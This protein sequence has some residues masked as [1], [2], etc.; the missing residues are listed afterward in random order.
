[1][2]TRR[3]CQR[4]V[5]F[6]VVCLLWLQASLA[7]STSAVLAQGF[8]AEQAAA[9]MSVADDLDV[10]LVASEP[11][12]RQ[13]VAL[14]FD[15][16]GR[17]WVIQYLQY[18]NPEGLQRVQVDR[19]SRTQYDR[20]P[21]PPPR[22]PRGAD[23]ISILSDSDADG[24][25]DVAHD[26]VNG[27]NLTTGLAFGD[28]GVYVLN[29]PYL[30]F[31]SDRDQNDQPDADPEVLLSG[32]GMED[33]H[34]VANSLTWGPDGWLY[35]CQGSTVTSVIR[36]QRF[37][38][39]VWRYHPGSREF[40]LFC[41]GGGNSWGLDF[42][43]VGRLFY[44][45][46]YGGFTLVHGVQGASYVK[47]FG[48]HGAL[49]N[50]FAYGYFEHAPHT[51]F[52]GGHVTVGG[53]VYQANALPER[54]RG[55]YVA[56]DLLGHSVQWHQVQPM[57]STVRTE[58]GG[59]LLQANDTWFATSDV[60]TGPDGALYVADWHDARMAH[61]DPDA[62]WDRRN[63]RIYRIG[64]RESDSSA[65]ANGAAFTAYPDATVPQLVAALR[66]PNQW[67]VRQARQELAWRRRSAGVAGAEPRPA[68]SSTPGDDVVATL[69]QQAVG[70]ESVDEALQALWTV[71]SMGQFKESLALPLL[72]SPH[73]AVRSWTVRLLGDGRDISVA[74][75]HR[76]DELAE[77][78]PDVEVRQQLA[79]SARFFPAEHA[80]P[81]INA[82]IN[83][84]IDGEDPFLPL[85]WWWAVEQHSVSGR[86]E[87]LKRFVRPTLWNSRL[88]RD[89]LLTRLV[90]RYAAE[91]TAAGWDSVQRLLIAAPD[92]SQRQK[93][94]AEVLKGW[95][96]TPEA[97][98]MA[99]RLA[100]IQPHPLADRLLQDWK[101]TP[102]DPE[103]TQLGLAWHLRPILEA[104]LPIAFDRTQPADRR[105]QI[106]RWSAA[107][108]TSE[109]LT[110]AVEILQSADEPE[111]VRMAALVLVAR[112]DR[113]SL[114]AALIR[115]HQSAELPAL[116][117]ALRD[118]ILGNAES[119]GL[120]LQAVERGEIAADVTAPEQ[121][122]RIALLQD[123]ALD[124]VVTKIWGR[125][126]ASTAEEKLAEVRRL[127][128]DLR[129]AP[130]DAV[131]G[132][133]LF[134]KHCAA[135]H[136]FRSEGRKIGPDLTTANR[137]DRDFLL[138]SLVDPS[139]TIR[140]EYVSAVIQTSAGQ[141]VH[142]LVVARTDDSL[143]LADA[144]GETQTLKLSEIE[145]YEDS[146]VSLMPENLYRQL[147]PQQLRDLFAWLQ[148][149]E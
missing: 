3:Q 12:V 69:Q 56:G 50:P 7:L 28:R 93:L 9:R 139:G 110:Q 106:L 23:R 4:G 87:V 25:L 81:I 90:R 42:D 26:F 64:P 102:T 100:L 92:A 88:G 40:Q 109:Q 114:T 53:I 15:P 66:H 148:M 45:T 14:E 24:L 63:G 112:L 76:L 94:W 60:T 132:H 41:E 22:G 35:G 80:V 2:K 27:L 130:G 57:G 16:R 118:L 142:G 115:V 107:A 89:V 82:N 34:S 79:C 21:E 149:G 11:V 83:R 59:T 141:I 122:R 136:Q 61:P 121:I 52:H 18:P 37:Q 108:A 33:A 86:E 124:A 20:I 123:P 1:M 67:H 105:A 55:R 119:A 97:A 13:P 113:G 129:A 103:L 78:E 58:H 77:L 70:A 95:L 117:S 6:R 145:V 68:D 44:S 91:G 29:V 128:N 46:N 101:E 85:L 38:Q 99:E 31:Y 116:R 131:A 65:E 133:M 48:K 8:P 71:A 120:W 54:Y 5:W 17:L 74:M 144:R 147:T 49:Q 84:D 62:D 47:S 138:I 36:G 126:Q 30:L 19:Y 125:L 73:A 137:Q 98:V 140:R 146:E 51:D 134:Q 96:D 39:G 104:V 72:D 111:T 10:R 143:T 32:F 135:C 43:A 127:N 75:A